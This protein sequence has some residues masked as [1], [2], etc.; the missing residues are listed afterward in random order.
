MSVEGGVQKLNEGA[1]LTVLEGVKLVCTCLPLITD[2]SGR[3]HCL[4]YQQKNP[5]N[6][7]FI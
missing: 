6:Q 4:A 5:H 7:V 2:L 1:I 3:L